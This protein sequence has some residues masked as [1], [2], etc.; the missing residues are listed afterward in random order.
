MLSNFG[1]LWAS[2]S[3]TETRIKKIK[4]RPVDLWGS[5][6]KLLNG[7]KEDKKLSYAAK[8]FVWIGNKLGANPSS[9]AIAERAKPFFLES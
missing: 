3:D 1:V 4:A 9:S 8:Y 2:L 7:R 6:R 5:P